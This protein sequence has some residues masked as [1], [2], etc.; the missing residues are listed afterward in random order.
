MNETTR[1]QLSQLV[2]LSSQIALIGEKGDFSNNDV[3]LNLLS[4][5]RE[6]VKV[7]GVLRAYQRYIQSIA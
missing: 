4:L 7:T 1:E 3:V 2:S 5:N 6:L